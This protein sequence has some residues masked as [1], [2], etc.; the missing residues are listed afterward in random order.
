MTLSGGTDWD[1]LE[2]LTLTASASTFLS[3][4]VGNVFQLQIVDDD[5][6]Q[7][8]IIRCEV[9]AYT[10]AT[11][12]SVRSNKTVPVALRT[13]ATTHW[14]KAVDELTGLW[15]L[16]GE[17]VSVF[18]DGFVV[19]SPNNESYTTY[20]I[21]NGTLSLD[22]AYGVIHVGIP[23]TAD[24][25]L[26]NLD[27]PDTET[28]SNKKMLIGKV[29]LF[30]EATRG[31]FAGGKPPSDDDVDPLEGLFEAK[32]RDLEGYDDPVSLKTG[33]V[34]IPIQNTW[35]SNG[36]VFIRQV[37]PLPL[38]ILSVSPEGYIPIK[39]GG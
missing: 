12:V 37:D 14:I 5:G 30:V 3:T 9:T 17:T 13:T 36:R 34:D 25:E 22:E 7:T 33:N 21:E 11:V 38:S 15:H 29:S 24:F 10:S 26:L 1:Y 32:L 16:E 20:T 2:T 27:R 35:N 19:G 8:D 23:I 31:I 6:N 39:K 4:D 28:L 18:A